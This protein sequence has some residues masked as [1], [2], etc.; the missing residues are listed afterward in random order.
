MVFKCL[1][2]AK[3]VNYSVSPK[4]PSINS[5]L[6]AQQTVFFPIFGLSIEPAL[7]PFDGL[8]DLRDLRDLDFIIN[9]LS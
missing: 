8:R 3:L 1:L 4:N 6:I 5:T 7:R 9:K 2:H